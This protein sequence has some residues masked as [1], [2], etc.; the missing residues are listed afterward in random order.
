M[1]KKRQIDVSCGK[2]GMD[3]S[4]Y[5]P[6]SAKRDKRLLLMLPET[7]LLVP[8]VLWL[9]LFFK[10]F[11]HRYKSSNKAGRLLTTKMITDYAIIYKVMLFI[12]LSIFAS[13][14]RGSLGCLSSL[15]FIILRPLFW[16]LCE[17][18]F[19]TVAV[20]KLDMH[21]VDVYQKGV[22]YC[23]KYRCVSKRE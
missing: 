4:P 2:L 19:V 18:L 9:C 16:T 1:K 13:V 7:Y 11:K 3:A 23:V 15:K 12:R 17:L 21:N 6:K 10:R 8:L 20:P 22:V 14:N 5:W